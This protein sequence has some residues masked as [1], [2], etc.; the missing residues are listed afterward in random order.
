MSPRWT[1]LFLPRPWRPHVDLGRTPPTF[2]TA[3]SQTSLG[4][5]LREVVG[6]APFGGIF[7]P[8]ADDLMRFVN[9]TF[10]SPP[11]DPEQEPEVLRFWTWAPGDKLLALMQKIRRA[12]CR[13]VP[14]GRVSGASGTLGLVGGPTGGVELV[15]NYRSGQISGF[16]FGGAQVGWNGGAGANG[17]TGFVWGLND[18]N[19]NYSGGFSGVNGQNAVGL[20]VQSSSGG[21]TGSAREL[22]PNPREVTSVAL[23]AGGSLIPTPTGGASVTN[24]TRP[25]QLGKW[26]MQASNINWIDT[27]LI[28]A[29][30]LCR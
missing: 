12:L 14:R 11:Q 27:P 4:Q 18:S 24:Y 22:I 7:F 6:S 15:Q 30:Q 5:V 19:S 17:Y 16:A 21:L 26:W 1:S 20:N 9:P 23:T 3:Q 13:A 28:G 25:L 10:F 29:N 8:G 2:P